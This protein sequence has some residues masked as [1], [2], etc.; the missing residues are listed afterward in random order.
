[1]YYTNSTLEILREEVDFLSAEEVDNY[2]IYSE[3]LKYIQD[4]LNLEENQNEEVVFA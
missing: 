1:M 3:G 4:R 2:E